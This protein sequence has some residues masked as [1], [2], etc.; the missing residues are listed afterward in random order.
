[1]LKALL[2]GLFG[3]L[4]SMVG[5]GATTGMPRFDFGNHTLW[6]G[7]DDLDHHWP[8]RGDGSAQGH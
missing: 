8:V 3:Y 7:F 1:M 5:I 4:L 6:G 2:M